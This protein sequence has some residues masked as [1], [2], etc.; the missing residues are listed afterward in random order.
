MTGEKETFTA[1]RAG[2]AGGGVDL[3]PARRR[4]RRARPDGPEADAAAGGDRGVVV[5]GCRA[6]AAPAG[7]T[8]A[9]ASAPA[10]ALPLPLLLPGALP[11]VELAQLRRREPHE[12]RGLDLPPPPKRN[13]AMGPG[14]TLSGRREH[15]IGSREPPPPALTST[16]RPEKKEGKKKLTGSRTRTRRDP[17]SPPNRAES[18]H[19][20]R[21]G[22]AIPP[23]RRSTSRSPAQGAGARARASEPSS[24]RGRTP[25]PPP[26]RSGAEH[27]PGKD[28]CRRG[29]DLTLLRRRRLRRCGRGGRERGVSGVGWGISEAKGKE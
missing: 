28:A 25:P 6:R 27:V 24:S 1:V 21:A 4:L 13:L 7:A 10:P 15:Q 22:R 20:P 18:R 26:S 11:P 3:G 5:L 8:A 12:T 9:A 29:S 17:A 2:A 14:T 23:H 16:K 19:A